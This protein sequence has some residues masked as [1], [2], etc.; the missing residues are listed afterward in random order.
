MEHCGP[1]GL[2]AVSCLD[3]CEYAKECMGDAAYNNYM[4]YR[5]T[6]LKKQ[7]LE[8]LRGYFGEDIKVAEEKYG[9][10]T[11]PYQEKEGPPVA[12]EIL[13]RL[14]ISIDDRGLSARCCAANIRQLE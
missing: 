13:S 4:D 8:K 9:S 12:R 11:G 10:S 1:E 6:G 2:I 3:W 14:G 5:V 7:L